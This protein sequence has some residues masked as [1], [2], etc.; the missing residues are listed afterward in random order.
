MIDFWGGLLGLPQKNRT[1][2]K[3]SLDKRITVCYSNNYKRAN[4]VKTGGAKLQGLSLVE[5]QPV[6]D[7][8]D[9]ILKIGLCGSCA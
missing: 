7:G 3:I 1:N 4:P 2:W 5:W 6:A 9:N 8:S